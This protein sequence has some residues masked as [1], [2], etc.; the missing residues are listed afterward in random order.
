MINLFC[1][2]FL[3]FTMISLQGC[4]PAVAGGAA[5]GVAMAHDRRTTGTILD[6]Q[7]IEVKAIHALS[8]HSELWKQSHI[9]VVSYNNVLLIVGQTPT[10]QLKQEAELALGDIAKVRKLH[11][12]L[13]VKEPISLAQRTKDSWIT[14]QIKAKMVGNKEINAS[15]VKVVTEDGIVYLMGI[16]KAEE[17]II[18]TDIAKEIE[19]VHKIVQIFEQI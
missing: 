10:E 12:E 11:N 19:G 16:V 9:G 2:F 3:L 13:E 14:T 6:D 4:I 15:R 8:K 7:G 1:T 17:A 18:A 5:T